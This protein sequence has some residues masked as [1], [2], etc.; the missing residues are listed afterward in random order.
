MYVLV[1]LSISHSIIEIQFGSIQITVQMLFLPTSDIFLS[2]PRLVLLYMAATVG[3]RTILASPVP[4]GTQ[5]GVTEGT[6][7]TQGPEGTPIY[8]VLVDR[9]IDRRAFVGFGTKPD[10]T[11]VGL[12]YDGDLP[13]G[14]IQHSNVV[15]EPSF[16][17]LIDLKPDTS[18]LDRPL[19]RV[20]IGFTLLTNQEDVKSVAEK[21]MEKTEVKSLGFEQGSDIGYGIHFVINLMMNKDAKTRIDVN[22]FQKQVDKIC[23][24]SAAHKHCMGLAERRKLIDN[25]M[26]AILKTAA[27][28]PE[29][30]GL[31]VKEYRFYK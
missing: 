8:L 11:I 9:D 5:V 28:V 15:G 22:A 12:K 25:V 18:R 1:D 6:Q 20:S 30:D 29:L 10:E 19:K 16:M 7:V 26:D 2:V 27:R 17:K 14:R 24:C 13:P 31:P 21:A 23:K 3:M 4:T